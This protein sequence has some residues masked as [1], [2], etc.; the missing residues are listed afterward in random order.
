M[1]YKD[2]VQD[3]VEN[4]RDTDLFVFTSAM[5]IA[6]WLVPIAPALVFGWMFYSTAKTE[7]K[8]LA[9]AGGIAIALG[10]VVAGAMSSHTAIT[11]Q[12][13]G[14]KKSKVLFA[15]GLVLAYVILEIGGLWTMKSYGAHL[16]VVGTVASL[17]TLT[18]YLARS[19]ATTLTEE[20][21]MKQ[22]TLAQVREDEQ[23]DKAHQRELNRLRLQMEQEQALAKIKASK[24]KAIAKLSV[25]PPVSQSVPGDTLILSPAEQNDRILH[26][27][28]QNPDTTMAQLAQD[29]GT[30]R[31]TLYRR[32]DEL[33]ANGIIKVNGAGYTINR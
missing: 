26:Y 6:P 25:S 14:V 21:E 22:N 24:E 3:R 1:S 29:V 27:M 17:L 2:F 8:D 28:E 16:E 10:L 12:S 5:G 20:K 11:L 30:S 33:K 32:L 18:V 7:M 15:W 31:S 19:S 13:Y 23:E 9:I 4:I